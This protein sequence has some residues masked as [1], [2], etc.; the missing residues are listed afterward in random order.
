MLSVIG[1]LKI[2]KSVGACNDVKING[3]QIFILKYLTIIFRGICG[4]T[5]E[6]GSEIL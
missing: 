6:D 4:I 3:S 2:E 5:P 1:G